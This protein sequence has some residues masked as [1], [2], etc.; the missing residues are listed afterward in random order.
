[1]HEYDWCMNVIDYNIFMHM[2][3]IRLP[4]MSTEYET[5]NFWI[6]I[7]PNLR[8][9]EFVLIQMQSD[10]DTTNLISSLSFFWHWFNSV[11]Y[12]TNDL[13]Y[14]PAHKLMYQYMY[15]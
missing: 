3:V 11:S 10:N 14:G 12:N 4:K 1:M 15:S 2:F 7:G 5:Q 13:S 6:R 9:F 8:I